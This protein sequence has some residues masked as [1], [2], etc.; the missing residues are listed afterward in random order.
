MAVRNDRRELA[1]IGESVE[2]FAGE[3]HLTHDD[4]AQINL[5]LDELVSNVIKYGYEDAAEHQ[6][7]VTVIVDADLI[8]IS[9]EDDGKPFNL[10]EAP[11]P[12]FELSIEERPIGGLGVFLVRSIADAVDYRRDGNR[13]IVTLKKE[14]RAPK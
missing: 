10:L 7:D 14:R 9:V 11:A 4:T 13:N 6:I 8:T 1:R 2:R 5:V 12:N 3:C